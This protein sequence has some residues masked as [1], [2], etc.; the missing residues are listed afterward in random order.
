MTL[1]RRQWI[2]QAAAATAGLQAAGRIRL[3]FGGD[4]IF[5]RG[6]AARIAKTG[7]SPLRDIAGILRSAD[8]AFVNLESPFSD[9]PAI[10]QAEMVF[11][12]SPEYARFLAEAGVDIVSTANNHVRDCGADGVGFTL[13]I[14]AQHK[15][16]AIG[17]GKSEDAA[18]SG[19]VMERGGVRFGFLAYTY[20]QSN[21]NYRDQDPRIAMLDVSRMQAGVRALRGKSDVVIVSMHAGA[22][23]VSRP[24]AAQ[25]E[26]A[27]AAIDAGAQMVAGHHPH[28]VQSME[29]YKNGLIL[30][31]LGN[32]VFDQR[33]PG[34]QR[35]LLA[36]ACFQ[37]SKL[38]ECRLI[39]V[40]IVDTVPRVSSKDAASTILL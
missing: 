22:E 6:V 24:Y 10:A 35:G 13:D 32:L 3:V 21:G 8:I 7:Q 18:Y 20:D 31:S 28:V 15:I 23:Y 14:M 30:Y 5:A 26:F 2:L 38:T 19:A 40:D 39:P 9:R 12:A 4:V 17:T 34:T 11:R 33:Q 37:G 25:I 16:L 29:I 27:R 36:E 1:G